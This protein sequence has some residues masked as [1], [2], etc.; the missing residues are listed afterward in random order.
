MPSSC[1]QGPSSSR[2]QV[3][4]S[5]GCPVRVTAVAPGVLNLRRSS[6][7]DVS[8][9]ANTTGF[10][11]GSL[12]VDPQPVQRQ[13]HDVTCRAVLVAE[14]PVVAPLTSN[15]NDVVG[16]SQRPGVSPKEAEVDSTDV[17]VIGADLAGLAA[18]LALT[19][20][21]PGTRVMVSWRRSL[22]TEVSSVLGLH[23]QRWH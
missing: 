14:R 23:L 20:A 19:R 15:V 1:G 6:R 3:L 17:A 11:S 22:I 7:A 10:T 18:A 21:Q 4:S 12:A 2:T 16:T 13:Q 8:V 5:S 9:A